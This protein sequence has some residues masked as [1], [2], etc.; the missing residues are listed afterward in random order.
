MATQNSAKAEVTENS[1]DSEKVSLP[2]PIRLMREVLALSVWALLFVQLLVFDITG[3]ISGRSATLDLIVRYRFLALLVVIAILWLLL[4]NRKFLH[5]CG[6]IL[7]YPFVVVCW[8]VPRLLFK[9][10]AIVVAFSPAV[11]SILNSFKASFI[12]F[13]TAFLSSFLI[14]LAPYKL[15]VGV[16]MFV[17]AVYLAYHFIRR[18]RV[19]FSPSTVF[20]DAAGAIGKAWESIKDSNLSRRPEELDPESDEYRQ[21]LGQNLLT[22]YMM[23]TGLWFFG[24]RLQEVMNSRKLDIYF[25][26]SLLY[27]FMLTAVL[28]ALEYLGLEHLFPGSFVGVQHPGLLDFLGLSF[29]TLMTSD[30]SPLK[31]ASGIAQISMYVQLFGSL[32]IIV[33][34]VF[35]ILTSI[36]ERYRQDLDCVISEM[37][38]AS[39][40][41]GALLESNY[42]LTIAGLEAWLFEFNPAITKWFLKLRHGEKRAKQ[43]EDE[44]VK[45]VETIEEHS[46]E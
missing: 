17:L 18:F 40:S 8:H 38:A 13:V 21:K 39:D 42:E 27:T 37:R 1:K 43:I 10:W 20:A 46:H 5:F 41:I 3:Y 33:L 24:E 12:I 11:Y 31:P 7:V 9:N 30:I 28:F 34:L 16:S 14:V 26:A 22:L 29:G 44:F 15:V 2:R 6:Y 36:R 25:L 35:V 32:L 4:G 45:E 19:A 23:T